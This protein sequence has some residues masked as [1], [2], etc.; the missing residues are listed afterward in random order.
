MSFCNES[1]DDKQVIKRY[2]INGHFVMPITSDPIITSILR[3]YVKSHVITHYR[4]IL[5]VISKI[6]NPTVEQILKLSKQ[7]NFPPIRLSQMIYMKKELPQ[8]LMKR[9]LEYDSY[10]VENHTLTKQ[11]ALQFENKVAIMLEHQEIVYM[12]EDELRQVPSP[13]TPDFLLL[14]PLNIF[15]KSIHWI[16]AKNYYGANVYLVI[17]NIEKQGNK[18][19]D[20]YGYGMFVFANGFSKNLPISN[21]YCYSFIKIN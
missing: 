16:D 1:T 14:S 8:K 21:K 4:H 13:Y 18:Y 6:T 15:N 7:Y 5:K 12:S 20:M 11:Q 2:F 10:S 17:Q 19:F 3:L 9:L